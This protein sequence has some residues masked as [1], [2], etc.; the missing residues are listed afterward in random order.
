[1]AK[2]RILI[3]EDEQL[4]ALEIQE[5]LQTLGYDVP[6]TASAGETAIGQAAA[7]RPNLV[8]MDIQ[9]SG[10]MDGIEAAETIYSRFD[11]PVIYLTA[12]SDTTTLERAKLTAPFGYVIKPYSK[13][14][15]HIAIECALVRH[16]LEGK[17]RRFE[18]QVSQSQ[19]LEAIGQLVAG[20]AHN[21]NNALGV[22]M[23]NL[24]LVTKIGP[25]DDLLKDAALAAE[26][27]A[28]MVKQLML[29][30]QQGSGERISIQ[31]QRLI[32]EIVDICRGTF[33]RKI[34]LELVPGSDLPQISG[35]ATLLRHVF[36]GLLV[37]ARDAVEA[38]A[39]PAERPLKIS[40][41]LSTEMFASAEERQHP[42]TQLGRY[43]RLDVRDN[44]IGMNVEARQRLFEPFFSTKEVGQGTG[45][46]L[47]TAYA[48]VREHGGWI[49]CESEVEQGTLFSVYLPVLEEVAGHDLGEDPASLQGQ[50]AGGEVVL[51]IEDEEMVRQTLGKALEHY[52]YTV[53]LAETGP[54]GLEIFMA[55]QAEI[56]LVVLDLSLPGM[57]G[58]EVLRRL[59]ATAP[60][61]KVIIA[62]GYALEP[63]QLEGARA[64]LYKPFLI[65]ELTQLVRGV[66]DA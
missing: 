33:D 49:A 40:I 62:T 65:D 41:A 39:Q 44:G 66:L 19:K 53:L 64:I 28:D 13:Q 23:G 22:I 20:V 7:L 11:I 18:E 24:D 36:L 34:D 32:A 25:D 26:K 8:L 5:Y 6:E 17:Q 54:Q 42:E 30:A 38:V 27:A 46:G 4:V 56:D 60:Q 47:S 15:L 45:L 2:A 1:M 16:E 12:H 21:F 52:G 61:V 9:L 10:Q 57:S 55:R 3:V 31:P 58:Y 50:L 48:V 37:N 59:R 14:E 43:I 29:F 35:D 63:D 51:F